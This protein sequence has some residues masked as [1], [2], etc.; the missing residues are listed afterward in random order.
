MEKRQLLP[1]NQSKFFIFNE[2][3]KNIKVIIIVSEEDIDLLQQKFMD[4]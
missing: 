2:F 3:S 1:Y 4:I